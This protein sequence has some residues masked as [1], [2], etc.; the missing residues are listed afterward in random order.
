MPARPSA[1]PPSI[2]YAYLRL[3]APW[4]HQLLT[5]P[6]AAKPQWPV[7]SSLRMPARS[8]TTHALPALHA[9]HLVMLAVG[10][11]L[12]CRPPGHQPRAEAGAHHTCGES[13]KGS[14]HKHQALLLQQ[15]QHPA[16]K[17]CIC[18]WAR[19]VGSGQALV[20]ASSER[21]ECGSKLDRRYAM[22]LCVHAEC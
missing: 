5:L 15:Q 7:Q 22:H 3:V 2:R 8:R 14:G 18:S 16:S 19:T 9:V 13:G 11:V 12:L 17:R 1:T 10:I 21:T 6:A 4:G 20:H